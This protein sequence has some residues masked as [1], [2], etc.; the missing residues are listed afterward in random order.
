MRVI[1]SIGTGAPLAEYDL[2]VE[3]VDG[4]LIMTASGSNSVADLPVMALYFPPVYGSDIPHGLYLGVSTNNDGSL[5]TYVSMF[6]A[7]LYEAIY[8]ID[9][10]YIPPLDSLTLNGADGKQYKLSVDESGQLV[11]AVVE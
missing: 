6:A 1:T 2:A 5:R 11:S 7:Y 4:P 3:D 9:P 8:P 10:K